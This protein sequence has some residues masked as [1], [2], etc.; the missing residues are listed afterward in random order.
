M[1]AW[2]IDWFIDWFM[3]LF[4]DVFIY[5]LTYLFVYLCIYL[6][7]HSFIHSLKTSSSTSSPINRTVSP[8]G[9]ILTNSSTT[10]VSKSTRHNKTS[11]S[12]I[13]H[14]VANKHSHANHSLRYPPKRGRGFRMYPPPTPTLLPGISGLSVWSDFSIYISSFVLLP[15][16]VALSVLKISYPF[17]LLARSHNLFFPKSPFSE[18]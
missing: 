18:R 10:Q 16:P 15:S 6:F 5:L 4:I 14:T 1:I 13:E 11:L 12:R 2:L 17:L 7:I 9:L 3:Y 8:Q